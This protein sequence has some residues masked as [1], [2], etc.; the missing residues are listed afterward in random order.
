[1]HIERFLPR[2]L[3]IAS[4]TTLAFVSTGCGA[5]DDSYDEAP[6]G[7]ALLARD[8]DVVYRLVPSEDLVAGSDGAATLE[9]I[10]ERA[11][12][13]HAWQI[14]PPPEPCPDPEE[15][16]THRW[17]VAAEPDGPVRLVRASTCASGAARL[18]RGFLLALDDDR[19]T[20]LASTREVAL[21][22][23]GGNRATE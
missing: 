6:T 10:D 9:R 13:H 16:P 18:E 14:T 8:G 22:S 17:S 3:S 12:R 15:A 1:M 7:G 2:L 19:L 20:V 4:V 21:R 5:A 11:A 23:V